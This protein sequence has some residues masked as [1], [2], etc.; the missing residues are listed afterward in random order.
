MVLWM[1]ELDPVSE[2][3]S[4]LVTVITS[5]KESLPFS[6]MFTA[7][8]SQQLF[9]KTGEAQCSVILLRKEE[10]DQQ[11]NTTISY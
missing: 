4:H 1:E 2:P 11:S 8:V 7:F 3:A 10:K 6:L 9:I 5:T